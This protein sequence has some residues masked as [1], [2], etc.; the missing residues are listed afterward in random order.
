MSPVLLI[1]CLWIIPTVYPGQVAGAAAA[2]NEGHGIV[3][4]ED[5]DI[6]LSYLE[7]HDA[8]I[9]FYFNLSN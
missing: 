6:L 2:L 4:E 8:L 3:E 7:G 9:L 5:D 1:Y